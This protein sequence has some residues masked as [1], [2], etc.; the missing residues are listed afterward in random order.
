[1][2]KLHRRFV[3]GAGD[4]VDVLRLQAAIGHRVDRG[5]GVQTE[6]GQIGDDA[7][8]GRFGGADDGDCVVWHR[9]S[10][11]PDGTREA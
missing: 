8:L 5:I 3:G 9:I 1:M 6:L 10:L 2:R 11:S 7:Q 4:A